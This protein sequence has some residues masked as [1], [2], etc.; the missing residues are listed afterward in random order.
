MEKIDDAPLPS[1]V[2]ASV[3]ALGDARLS[4]KFPP[5]TTY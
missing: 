2:G 5:A 3:G 4:N 1:S